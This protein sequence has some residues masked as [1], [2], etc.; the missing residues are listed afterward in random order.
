MIEGMAINP[1]LALYAGLGLFV[2]V[3]AYLIA[4]SLTRRSAPV[5]APSAVGVALA[6]GGGGRLT[7]EA[8][9]QNRWRYVDLDHGLIFPAGDSIGWDVAIRRF[10][11]RLAAPPHD[12]GKWY[13]YGMLSHLL[14]PAG[15]PYDILTTEG[16]QGTLEVLSYYC[17]G[18]EAGCLTLQYRLEPAAAPGP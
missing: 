13:R 12:L 18:L 6:D 17:P 11:V 4:T 8:R 16:R 3:L 1:R 2:V 7:V 14:E 15:R 9:D 5:F 10:H